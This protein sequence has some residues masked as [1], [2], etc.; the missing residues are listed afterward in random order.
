MGKRPLAVDARV[1][2]EVDQHDLAPQTGAIVRGLS[3]G[4]LSH[5]VMPLKAGA[6][7]QLD[8][9]SAA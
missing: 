7:P 1:R 9:G 6:A 8:Q 4:V 3:P 5:A 2:P